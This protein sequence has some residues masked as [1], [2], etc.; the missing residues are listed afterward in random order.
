[1][2]RGRGWGNGRLGIRLGFKAV[3]VDS[4]MSDSPRAV[5]ASQGFDPRLG[6]AVRTQRMA[7]RPKLVRSNVIGEKSLFGTTFIMQIQVMNP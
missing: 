7:I 1:M 6:D 3:I 5:Y 4:N 2:R